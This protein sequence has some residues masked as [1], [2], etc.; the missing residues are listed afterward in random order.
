MVSKIFKNLLGKSKNEDSKESSQ[1]VHREI[2]PE[3]RNIFIT[4]E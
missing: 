2:L 1:T 3:V 4:L